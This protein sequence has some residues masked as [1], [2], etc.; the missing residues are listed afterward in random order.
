MYHAAEEFTEVQFPYCPKIFSMSGKDAYRKLEEISK[1]TAYFSAALSLVFW[2]QRTYMPPEGYRYRGELIS[3]IRGYIHS[4]WTSDE[5]GELLRKA[6]DEDL[7]DVERM[8]LYWWRRSYEKNTKIPAEL[9]MEMSRLSTETVEVWKRARREKDFEIVKPYLR[10]MVELLRRRAHALGY[11]SE[12]YDALL[13]DYEPGLTA[14]FVEGIFEPLEREIKRLL[15]RV[16]GVDFGEEI[17]HRHYPK[18]KQVEFNHYLLREIGYDFNRGRLDETVHPFAT[19]ILPRDVRITTR[20]HENFLSSGLFGTLHEMGHALYNM[21]LPEE[22]FGLPVG[23]PSSLSLHESQSRFWENVVGRSLAFW[24]VY[25]DDARRYFDALKDVDVEQFYRAINA[26][27]PSTIRVEADELTYNLHIILR[28]K[29]ERAL[30]NGQMEVDEVRDAW[31]ETFRELFGFYPPDDSEGIL[32]DI[33]WY[34]GSMGYFPTY[35]LGNLIS[36]QIYFRMREELGDIQ[37]LILNKRFGDILGYLRDRIHRHGSLYMPMDI[38]KMATGK[39]LGYS[40][41]V[42]YIEEKISTLV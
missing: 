26:M 3:T 29:L 30:I 15:D 23:N 34:S 1:K 35:A 12:P 13:D 16:K 21:N 17:L 28:F 9:L 37:E 41:F 14:K 25:L 4:I 40:D 32:Q 36:A 18:Q 22:Y 39:E 31:N 7:N 5:V 2:D 38:V 10:K 42:K 24:K 20:Y 11:G 19:R 8:N 33:H 27:K 6:E